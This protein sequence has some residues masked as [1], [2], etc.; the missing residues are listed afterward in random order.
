MTHLF[1]LSGAYS[2]SAWLLEV[3]GRGRK[4]RMH[5]GRKYSALATAQRLCNLHFRSRDW[6][7]HHTCSLLL[8]IHLLCTA[9]NCPRPQK[10]GP[11]EHTRC[12]AD[13]S[14]P[15]LRHS[16]TPHS[17]GRV[18]LP[19]SWMHIISQSNTWSLPL[20]S[21]PLTQ[22]PAWRASNKQVWFQALP[23]LP[24]TA[25]AEF[26]YTHKKNPFSASS[27]VVNL[28]ESCVVIW[29]KLGRLAAEVSFIAGICNFNILHPI[30][31]LLVVNYGTV[32]YSNF[33]N[34]I[35]FSILVWVLQLSRYVRRT[36]IRK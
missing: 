23:T 27:L 12:P 13:K 14:S 24:M 17:K 25:V 7:R 4:K 15:G 8:T 16:P 34:I 21:V 32:I 1:P 35:N 18:K 20:T 19:T 3:I 29:C 6:K 9:K 30:P 36:T 10:A 2:N 11:P 26:I 22:K 31:Y 28:I 33:F 5:V